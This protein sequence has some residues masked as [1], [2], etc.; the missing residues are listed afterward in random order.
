L[1]WVGGQAGRLAARYGISG[2]TL[3]QD[4]A[5]TGRSFDTILGRKVLAAVA[6]FSAGLGLL[7]ALQINGAS[8]PIGTPLLGAWAVRGGRLRPR[9]RRAAVGG[10]HPPARL[11][12]RPRPTTSTWCP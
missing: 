12:A 5:L 8:V 2:T 11:P 1:A 10:A 9:R 7:A 3:R 6:G 4:A